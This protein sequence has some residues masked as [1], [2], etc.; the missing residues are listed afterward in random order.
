MASI[1]SAG[2]TSATAMVH[3]A[4]TSG[5]LQLASNNGTVAL[6]ID[7]SQQFGFG[8][9]SPA[10][11]V[12]LG[13]GTT[14]ANRIRLQRGSDDTSQY[15]TLG[16]NS[17]S[18][19]RSVAL[20]SNQTDISF[21]QV[22]S[23]GTRTPLYISSAG[24]IGIGTTSPAFSLQIAGAT[25][26][27]GSPNTSIAFSGGFT[28]WVMSNGTTGAGVLQANANSDVRLYSNAY[29]GS[30]GEIQ[31][32]GTQSVGRYQIA[33]G[34][35]NWGYSPSGTTGSIITVSNVMTLDGSG[36]LNQVGPQRIQNGVYTTSASFSI[37]ANS[38]RRIQVNIGNYGFIKFRLYGLRTN[39]GNCVVWWEGVL[40]NNNVT[41]YT[42]TISQQTSS[43]SISFSLSSP[44]AGV[45]NFDFNNAGSGGSGWYD[46]QDYGSGSVTVTTY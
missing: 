1:L 46:K 41:S 28:G 14:V 21:N 29:Y 19:Y 3:T 26:A 43:G 6:T 32:Y 44:S 42:N 11:Q 25:N 7:T 37:D 18:V 9:T 15:M 34:S 27:I 35:H 13:G 22:G 40:N 31:I 38:N 33:S 12:D 5:V 45:W 2:T 20:A 4:D 17:L 16:W 23:D 30:G 39:G 36:N 8:T 24:N 10:F